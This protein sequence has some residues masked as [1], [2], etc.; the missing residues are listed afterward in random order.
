MSRLSDIRRI[1]ADLVCAVAGAT[2]PRLVD[3]FAKVPRED[4]LGPGPWSISVPRRYVETPSDDPAY[5][6]QNYLFAID[7]DRKL[8]NGE[9]A[10]LARMIDLLELGVGDTVVH[11]GTGVGYYTAVMAE[12]VGNGGRVEGVEVDLDLAE[13]SRKSLARY[14]QVEITATNG[15]DL[16]T[17]G[18]DALFINAG[19][20]HPLPNWLDALA[21]GGRLVLPL[22]PDEG[23]GVVMKI[24]RET[25]GYTASVVSNIWIFDCAGA[26]D[27]RDA[28][29]LARALKKGGYGQVQTLRRGRHR[30]ADTCWLHGPGWCFSTEALGSTSSG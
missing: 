18:V 24:K 7:V 6:Y 17:S 30:R 25:N 10:F 23:G 1:Y 9:P 2:D 13:R 22:T 21:P 29:R 27:P 12:L 14:H 16:G 15:S 11:V 8:N 28:R 5:L 4:Y 20:T 3:A 19:A 26:R